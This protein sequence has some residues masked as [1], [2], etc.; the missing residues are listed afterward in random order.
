MRKAFSLVEL[1]ITL[2]ISGIL[3][4][5]LMAFLYV[6]QNGASSYYKFVAD[7]QVIDISNYLFRDLSGAFVLPYDP[8]D[9]N[10]QNKDKRLLIKDCFECL[11]DNEGRLKEIKFITNNY[12]PIYNGKKS[13]INR[14]IYKL[15]KDG[16][17]YKLQR[18]KDLDLPELNSAVFY[19]ILEQIKDCKIK[20]YQQIENANGENEVKIQTNWSA[21]KI[22][23]EN[24]DNDKKD[25][26]LSLLPQQVVFTI[27]L[28]SEKTFEFLI[29]IFG[30][31]L[32]LDHAD[33][34]PEQKK[35]E[36]QK[37]MDNK[38]NQKQEDKDSAKN[39]ED[40]TAQKADT[41]KAESNADKLL[42]ESNEKFKGQFN[43]QV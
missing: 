38:S 11:S 22:Y 30:Y 14:V 1:I 33:V 25:K 21:N 39:K 17:F 36:S 37:S 10:F 23:Q 28:Q 6:V 3:F 41:Q 8:E 27:T 34:K 31:T 24:R 16:E 43:E 42:D 19:T 40:M 13:R 35:Q 12:L 9:K 18:S 4:G 32:D 15:E 20:L 2:A 5:S 7:D 26:T 29:P